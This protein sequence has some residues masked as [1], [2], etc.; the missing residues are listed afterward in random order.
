MT[1]YLFTFQSMTQAQSAQRVLQSRAI[2]AELRR[3]P[4]AV[5]LRGC[6]YCLVVPETELRRTADA[7]R[8]RSVPYK[9]VYR[10]DD[11]LEEVLL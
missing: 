4:R 6:G 10:K 7:F 3:T 9:K 8:E 2:A 5:A 11:G 1:E